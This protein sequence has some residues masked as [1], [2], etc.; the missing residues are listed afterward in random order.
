M[1]LQVYASITP[2]VHLVNVVRGSAGVESHANITVRT[3][4]TLYCTHNAVS[5]TAYGLPLHTEA[6]LS[7]THKHTRMQARTR[8]Q[9]SV[10][11]CKSLQGLCHYH[12]LSYNDIND[13]NDNSD[14]I[15]FPCDASRMFMRSSTSAHWG[16]GTEGLGS[17][18]YNTLPMGGNWWRVPATSRYTYTIWPWA[19]QCCAS[20]RMR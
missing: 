7:V 13:I 15:S 14:S 11:L 6:W 20:K 17:G 4:T 10:V 18:H 9:A 12:F 3:W 5:R 19:R 2:V 16:A 8:T 1:V